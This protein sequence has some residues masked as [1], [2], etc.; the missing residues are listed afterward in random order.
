MKQ[1]VIAAAL[2][3][4]ITSASAETFSFIGTGTLYFH[5]P[6][7]FTWAGSFEVGSQADGFYASLPFVLESNVIHFEGRTAATFASGHLVNIAESDLSQNNGNTLLHLRG[8]SLRYS[9]TGHDVITSGA[10]AQMT[11]HP[12]TPILAPVPEPETWALM[13]AGLGGI[14]AMLRRRVART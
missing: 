9:S 12:D 5:E 2:A 8:M 11:S 6:Q 4:A 3:A 1:L 7:S 13:L 14:G 10:V